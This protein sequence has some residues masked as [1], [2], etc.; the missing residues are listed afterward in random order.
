MP[1]DPWKFFDFDLVTDPTVYVPYRLKLDLVTGDPVDVPALTVRIHGEHIAF[2]PEPLGS[3]PTTGITGG[4]VDIRP[5]PPGLKDLREQHP[6]AY[7]MWRS[8]EAIAVYQ[9]VREGRAYE[10][11]ADHVGRPPEHVATKFERV[12]ALLRAAR[13]I[14]QP[15]D[16]PSYPPSKIRESTTQ[17]HDYD[18]APWYGAAALDDPTVHLPCTLHLVQYGSPPTIDVSPLAGCSLTAHGF[19]FTT[20]ETWDYLELTDLVSGWVDLHPAPADLVPLREAHDGA[21]RAWNP[22]DAKQV[23]RWG[24]GEPFPDLDRLAERLSRPPAHL[25]RKYRHLE[26]A[27]ARIARPP[28]AEPAPFHRNDPRGRGD[29]CVVVNDV[30]PPAAV[31]TRHG[32][33]PAK[34]MGWGF[35]ADLTDD[36]ITTLRTDPDVDQIEEP[37]VA[38]LETGPRPVP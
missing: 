34:L 3:I 33:E 10:E 19:H 20:Q 5:A 12:E 1:R 16:P 28:R 17:H 27:A 14:P 8:D 31:A 37:G 23:L 30:A 35:L 26:A 21:Y 38:T 6:S 7:R 24:R 22:E 36:Q 13:T 25:P 2:E 4:R 29:H 11:I 15:I 32:I 18:P 9:W